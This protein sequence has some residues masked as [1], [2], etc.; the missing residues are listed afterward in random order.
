MFCIDT[1]GLFDNRG[2]TIK[3]FIYIAMMLCFQKIKQLKGIIVMFSEGD[4]DE[5][6][7]GPI[8]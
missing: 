6:R 7:A 4:L 8:I 2:E 1:A 3:V 5:I